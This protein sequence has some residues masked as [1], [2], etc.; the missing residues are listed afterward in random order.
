[1]NSEPERPTSTGRRPSNTPFGH[2]LWFSRSS[3]AAERE[4][5]LH[6]TATFDGSP[7]LVPL[8]VLG[9]LS[10][11]S[12]P[13]GAEMSASAASVMEQIAAAAPPLH[14]RGDSP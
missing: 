13:A 1:M 9:A 10:R 7:L 11:L 14:R 6:D 4:S 8:G 2:A 12:G 3:N 5:V